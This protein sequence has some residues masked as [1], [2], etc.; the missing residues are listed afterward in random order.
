[1]ITLMNKQQ[2]ILAYFNEGKALRAI[3]RET[4]ID[5]KTVRKYVRDYEEKRRQLFD[6]NK[7]SSSLEIIDAIVEE[8]KYDSSTGLIKKQL[9]Q[10]S[11]L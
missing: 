1:M 11:G 8:P 4:G 7:I 10:Q 6:S 3:A 9:F 2:I 5:R